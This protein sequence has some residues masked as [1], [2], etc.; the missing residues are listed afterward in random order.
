M[1]YDSDRTLVHSPSVTFVLLTMFVAFA[2]EFS[3]WPEALLRVK[4]VFPMLALVYWAMNKPRMIN[5]A[6]AVIVGVMMDL[7]NQTTFGFNVAACSVVV[8][9]TNVVGGR[10]VLLGGF[11]Q[12]VHI[13][14]VLAAGQMTLLSLEWIFGAFSF[15]FEWRL[16]YPSMSAAAMWSA[17]PL[18]MGSLRRRF[19][20]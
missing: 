15:S 14:A 2:L 8:F 4:P 16:F 1:N 11:G 3:P 10:F 18:L 9:M 19:R 5:Y 12:A 7:A 20:H 17:L 13:F 6:A